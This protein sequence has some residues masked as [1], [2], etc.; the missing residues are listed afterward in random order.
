LAKEEGGPART[1]NRGAPQAEERAQAASRAPTELR[2][3][4]AGSLRRR[5]IYVN[6]F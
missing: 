4:K 5:G 1:E 2:R 3:G 6:V